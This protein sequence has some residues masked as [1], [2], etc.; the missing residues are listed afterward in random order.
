MSLIAHFSFSQGFIEIAIVALITQAA[1]I[2]S[3]LAGP[4]T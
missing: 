2:V 3:M 4:A 1:N